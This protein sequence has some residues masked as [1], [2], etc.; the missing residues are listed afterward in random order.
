MAD[1][2]YALRTA[3]SV[4]HACAR[5][6]RYSSEQSARQH[7]QTAIREHRNTDRL[8]VYACANCLHWH[9]TKE[10]CRSPAVTATALREGVA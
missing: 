2:T 3:E 10:P 5:K 6:A 4:A 9:L 1:M 8:F 7:A